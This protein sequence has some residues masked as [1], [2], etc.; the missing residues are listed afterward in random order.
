MIHTSAFCLAQEAA[1]RDRAAATDLKNVQLIAMSAA[2]AW[3]REAASALRRE[4]KL[5]REARSPA[6][7]SPSELKEELWV[8]ENPDRG[9]AS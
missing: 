5:G 1:Q 3:A 6:V 2:A 9:L 4:A 8:S 7:V